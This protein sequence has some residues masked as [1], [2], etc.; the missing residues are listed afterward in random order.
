MFLAAAL[1][2]LG[3]ACC[4][5]STYATI[6]P[7]SMSFKGQVKYIMV[8]L[9]VIV[10]IS[11]FFLAMTKHHIEREAPQHYL[12][13]SRISNLLM[14]VS[15]VSTITFFNMNKHIVNAH[16]ESVKELFNIIP[17]VKNLAFYDWLVNVTTNMIFT[18]S[19]CVLL[20]VM[21]IK[22]PPVGFDLLASI[23]HKRRQHSLL[24]MILAILMYKPKTLIESKYK[25]LYAL[26]ELTQEV[27]TELTHELTQELV[28]ELTPQLVQE[29]STEKES[30]K[31][32][33]C[34]NSANPNV[35][36]LK[37]GLTHLEN[38]VKRHIS[39]R[40]E[41]GDT[42]NVKEIRDKFNL[43]IRQWADIREKLSILSAKGTKTLVSMSR[44][45]EVISG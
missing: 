9:F 8:A 11:V 25:E 26:Q 21:A 20:D 33:E 31:K 42:V 35:L 4:V 28:Q 38:K 44:K 2:L 16:S 30:T 43:T 12:L 6:N 34:A 29:V 15:I 37:K 10:Q 18:W 13:V 5:V 24:G 36:T 7:I 45:E 40:Y 27:N 41:N 22:L 32:E 1:I 17:Y 39:E 19:V 3:I 23:K 14:I